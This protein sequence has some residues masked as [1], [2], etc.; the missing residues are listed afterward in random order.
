MDLY[1]NK[2]HFQPDS[3]LTFKPSGKTIQFTENGVVINKNIEVT[4]NKVVINK[5]EIIN[6]NGFTGRIHLKNYIFT[7]E[8]SKLISIKD[9]SN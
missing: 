5:K 1:C 7:I 9:G 4:E 6:E 8:N 2:V 3:L